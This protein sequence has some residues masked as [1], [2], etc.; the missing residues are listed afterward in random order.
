MQLYIT[1]S[2]YIHKLI[3]KFRMTDCNPSDVPADPCSRLS[4]TSCPPKET[5]STSNTT[6]YRALIGGLLYVMGLTRPDI[7]FAVIAVSRYCQNPGRAHW[8]AAKLILAYLTS[9]IN[10]GLR[11][12]GSSSPNVLVSYCDS[13]FA[14]CPDTRRSTSGVLFLLNGAPVAWKSEMQKPI[15]QSTAEAEYYAAGLASKE[16]VWMREIMAQLGFNQSTP[17][18][19]HCDNNSAIRIIYNPE[20]HD[21]TKH[22]ELKHHFIRSQV[23]AKNL[24]MVPVSS[25]NQ[26]ADILTKPLAGPAFKVNRSRIGVFEKQA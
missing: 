19:T 23:Q 16:N 3:A 2:I 11:F 9:T 12:C 14:G 25:A 7:A 24:E 22:I 10:H 6:A 26:L 21:R 15:A 8:K 1:Q 20:F 13:D 17:T 5:S 4:V 18:K